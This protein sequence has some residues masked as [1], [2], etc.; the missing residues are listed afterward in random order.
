MRAKYVVPCLLPI[1][2]FTAHADCSYAPVGA[3]KIFESDFGASV[4][5]AT[6]TLNSTNSTNGWWPIGGGDDG[7]N[8]PISVNGGSSPGLQPISYGPII[9]Y[10][11]TSAEIDCGG[12]HCW[13]AEIISG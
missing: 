4:A 9:S 13:K 1:L 11:A 2:S 12:S 3:Q 7:F 10:D 6:P 5:M 8:W